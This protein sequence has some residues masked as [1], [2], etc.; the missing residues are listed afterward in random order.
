MSREPFKTRNKP[1]NRN[2]RRVQEP[3]RISKKLKKLR[4]TKR[5]TKRKMRRILQRSLMDVGAVAIVAAA[6]TVVAAAD[7]TTGVASLTSD[8]AIGGAVV[9][10]RSGVDQLA[11]NSFKF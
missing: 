2:S 7:G 1:I 4:K 5:R 8:A 10:D 3:V 11:V 6:A 9:L